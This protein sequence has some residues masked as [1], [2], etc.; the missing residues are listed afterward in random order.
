MPAERPQQQPQEPRDPQRPDGQPQPRSLARRKLLF[1]A[2]AAAGL[3][4]TAGIADRLG[5]FGGGE[6]KPKA[7]TPKKK[8]VEPSSHTMVTV[9]GE[10]L[11]RDGKQLGV[12]GTNC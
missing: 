6:T 10:K 12:Y 11:M 3:A 1:G 4:V 7:P 5:F 8:E 2:T 9:E